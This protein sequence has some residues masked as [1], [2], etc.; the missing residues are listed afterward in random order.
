MK[1]TASELMRQL[2]GKVTDQ[3][4]MGERFIRRL[5]HGDG[6]RYDLTVKPMPELQL[7]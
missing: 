6:V 3:W 1:A 7:Q 2:P 5:A 4:P